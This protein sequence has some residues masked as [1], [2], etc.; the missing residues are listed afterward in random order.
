[1]FS[2]IRKEGK[3][4]DPNFAFSIE[5]PSEFY[6]PILD[7]YHA[8][9]LHQGRWPRSGAGV[10]GV[11]L[12]T[13]VYHDYRP[14]YGSEGCYVS[15]KPSRLALYQMGMN[16]VCGKVPAVA[17]WGRWCDPEK[18]DSPQRRLLRAHLDLW[19]GPAGEFL[20]FGQRVAAPDLDVPP[21]EMTFTEKDGKTRRPLAVPAVLHS[22]WKLAEGRAGTIF[23]CVH[24]KPVEFRFGQEKLVLDPGEAS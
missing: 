9:D 14:G 3:A 19:R 13:H 2:E 21:L 7:T 15:E 5:E 18:L 4:G 24:D 20:N 16:L 8:R 11:P 1:M 23:A 17:I 10:L 22:A 12:F 6:L